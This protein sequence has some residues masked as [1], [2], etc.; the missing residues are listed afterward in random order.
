MAVNGEILCFGDSNTYGCDPRGSFGGR[1]ARP[2]PQQ[3]SALLC[4]GVVNAGEN[5]REIPR[6]EHEIMWFRELFETEP[7]GMLIVMLGT[8]DLL[9]G[10]RPEETAERMRAFLEKSPTEPHKTM[11]I[12][13]PALQPGAWVP[14]REL[15]EASKRLGGLYRALASSLGCRFA[16]AGEWGIELAYDGVHFTQAGH[17]AFA[18]A[19]AEIMR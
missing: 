19:L 7:V 3:L 18:A 17:A 9:Q 14:S 5:G 6:R 15:E 1:Y 11:L 12:A 16:D 13:P 2:W 8:N 4:R 10:A